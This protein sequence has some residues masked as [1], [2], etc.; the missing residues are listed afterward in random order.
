MV[1][2]AKRPRARRGSDLGTVVAQSAPM[3]L[4]ASLLIAI[5]ALG[6]FDC[7]W[8]HHR[9]ARLGRTPETRR[10][11]WI[12]VARGVV[13]ALQ[14]AFVARF[15]PGGAWVVA[16]GALFVADVSIAVADVLEEP[17]SRAAQ[18]GLPRGEYLTH[19]VLSVMVGVYLHGVGREAVGWW[20][21]PTDLRLVAGRLPAAMVA[22]LDVMAVGSLALAALEAAG[23][24]GLGAA[25]RARLER[26]RPLHVRVRLAAPLAR[27]WAVTQDHH[28]HPCWDHR[29]SRIHMLDDEIRT[30][31]EMRYEK[32]VLGVTIAGWGRYALHRP[33]RQSTFAFGS[34]DPR[35]LIRSGVGL[36]IYTPLADGT[37]ELST[38]YTYAVRWGLVGELID[39]LAFRPLFQWE[40]ERSFRRLGRF[41]PLAS[42]VVGRGPGRKPVRLAPVEAPA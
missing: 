42:E 37:V 34:D 13:Y 1:A 39:R 8:F 9:H 21:L 35:S 20:Q 14:F 27:V 15:E 26:P 2:R 3:L 18:G 30:G 40:T 22:V 28:L 36:W 6:A 38:S 32:D 24:L 19:I 10:E 33:L 41:L 17:R 29:F 4:V 23:L 11:A 25:L 7:A 31:T 16:L 5:G 12:H